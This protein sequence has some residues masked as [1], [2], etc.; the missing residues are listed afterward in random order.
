M[1][2]LRQFTHQL[3][4]TASVGLLFTVT[5]LSGCGSDNSNPSSTSSSSTANQSSSAAQKKTLTIEE[6]TDGYCYQL[7]TVD[8][9]HT[10]YSGLGYTNS[11]NEMGAN[12]YWA[13]EAQG[14]EIVEI[15]FHFA[16]GSDTTRNAKLVSASVEENIEFTSTTEWTNW[17]DLTLNIELNSGNNAIELVSTS[18]DGLANIDFISVQGENIS[19]GDCT[20]I[21]DIPDW[22]EI[23]YS[24]SGQ[25]GIHD[26]STI[27]K[28][29]DRYWTFGTGIGAGKPI[30]ALYSYDLINWQSGPSPIPANTY[31]S[32][33]NSKLPTFDGNFWAPDIIQM[34]G[35]YYLYYSAFS[36]TVLNSAIGVMVSDSLNNPNW[37]DL[38]MVVSTVDEPRSSQNEPVNAID[39]GLYRDADGRVWMIYGSHYAGIFIREINPQTGL[40]LNNTRYNAAGN[41]GGWNEYEAAQVQYL[42][43]YYYLFI[44]LGDCCQQLDSDYIMYVARSTNPTGPFITQSGHDL[45]NGD[46]ISQQQVD[47]GVTT[48]SVLSSQPGFVGPGHFGYLL[49]KGQHLASIHYYGGNDGW[50]HLRLLEMTFE[51]GWPTLDYQFQ[52]R[53]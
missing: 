32:W 51:N 6:N 34:N 18:V 39:A 16:N 10:G 1:T 13:I 41:N 40:L 17:Q 31:P 52:L 24:V 4:S 26:P 38:G 35:R 14:P 7:G 19:I 20:A 22:T 47:A 45:W 11:S 49:N 5:V 43:G 12:I 33:I 29:G 27:L 21:S 15:T 48:G 28:D 46:V 37:Q 42:N 25:D 8:N 23:P 30:N 44:N 9:E 50:G 3:Y 36:S 53:Q 2:T